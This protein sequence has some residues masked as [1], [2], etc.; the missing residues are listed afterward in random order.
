MQIEFA[1][2]DLVKQKVIQVQSAL[3]AARPYATDIEVTGEAC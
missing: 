2:M 1:A 3:R